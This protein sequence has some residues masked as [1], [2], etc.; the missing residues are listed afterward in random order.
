MSQE[1]A[2]D[3]AGITI[4]LGSD[5]DLPIEAEG[6]ARKFV[7]TDR[8]QDRP[9]FRPEVRIRTSWGEPVEPPA[10]DLLFD[11]GKGLWR[12]YRL[13]R[14]HRFVFT[15]P[16]LGRLPYQAASFNED[17][18]EGEVEIRREVFGHRLPVYPLQYPLDEL[19]MV[20]LLSHGRGVEVHGSGIVSPDGSGTLFAGQSGAGKTTMAK[21]WLAEPGVTILSDERVVLRQEGDDI[22]MYGTPWHGDGRIANQGR[23]RLRRIFFLRHAERNGIAPVSPTE[24]IARLFSCGFAPFHDRE[25]LDYTLQF[26]EQ[27]VNHCICAELGFRPDQSAVAFV[28]NN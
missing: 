18:S 2:L 17:F 15:A 13:G 25:G 16:L 23:T 12:L 22:W 8:P 19:L 14:G 11:P 10:A 6:A 20:H 1:L 9:D 3:I 7:C 4:A 26:L 27:V 21:L 5:A 24:S 28:R